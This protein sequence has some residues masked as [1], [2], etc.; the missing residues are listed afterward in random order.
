MTEPRP[1]ARRS[2]QLA[3]PYDAV[4]TPRAV[5]EAPVGLATTGD[6]IFNALWTLLHVPCVNVPGWSGPNHM[7]VGL[8]LLGARFSDRRVLRAA[9]VLASPENP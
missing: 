4:L 8:T 2:N 3:A 6:T 1:P 9:E 7:P 5:G